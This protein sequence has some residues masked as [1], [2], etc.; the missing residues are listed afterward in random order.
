MEPVGLRVLLA[1][2]EPTV[3]DVVKRCLEGLRVTVVEASCGE[4][5]LDCAGGSIDLLIT[6]EVMEGIQGHEL[7]RRLRAQNPRLK[8]L[9]LTG[10]A[11]DLFDAKPAMGD[12]E[13]F[14]EKP[15]TSSGLREAI[16]MLVTDRLSL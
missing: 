5:A 8:V 11:D 7:A 13:A 4:D 10:H 14:L 9:Y 6:D 1:D 15:F 2:D 12:H 3:R 16:A